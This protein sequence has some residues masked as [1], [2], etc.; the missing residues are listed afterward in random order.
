MKKALT[1]LI[2]V[3]GIVAGFFFIRPNSPTSWQPNTR[4]M[5]IGFTNLATKTNAM[6][7]VTNWPTEGE[8]SW[9]AREV[10]HLEGTNWKAFDIHSA[11]YLD[12]YRPSPTDAVPF[13]IVPVE[14]VATPSRIVIE[15]KLHPKGVAKVMEDLRGRWA[16]LNGRWE[17]TAW[18]GPSY[19]ITNE[20]SAENSPR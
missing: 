6:F 16:A 18:K 8:T 19:F 12:W 3:V 17:E 11:P 5:F 20:V 13:A 9:L 1:I 4:L 15:L 10:S 2:I 7:V 14:T